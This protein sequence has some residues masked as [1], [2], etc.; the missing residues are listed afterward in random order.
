MTHGTLWLQCLQAKVDTFEYDSQISFLKKWI[1]VFGFP[2]ILQRILSTN[3][4]KDIL[5]QGVQREFSV[6]IRGV[7][8][9]EPLLWKLKYTESFVLPGQQQP[10]LGR[11]KTISMAFPS[12]HSRIKS[13][14]TRRPIS[15]FP[16]NKR[17]EDQKFKASLFYIGSSQTAWVLRPC[18]NSFPSTPTSPKTN[19]QKPNV[20]GSNQG[21]LTKA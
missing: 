4:N 5:I 21:S 18:H 15:V 7:V 14:I 2:Q 10:G 16:T 11:T 12:T 19:N 20:H 8:L 3:P 1:E 9:K 13:R 17:Q 6:E